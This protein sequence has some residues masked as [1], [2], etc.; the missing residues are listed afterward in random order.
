[1]HGERAYDE[2]ALWQPVFNNLS[3]WKLRETGAFCFLFLITVINR[4]LNYQV[5]HNLI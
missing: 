1:L 2:G 3:Y 4:L 5:L